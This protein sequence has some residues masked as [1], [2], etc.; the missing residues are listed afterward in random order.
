MS[1][2]QTHSQSM[3]V[4]VPV[5]IY[6]VLNKTFFSH[7]QNHNMGIRHTYSQPV[8]TNTTKRHTTQSL[9][10]FVNFCKTILSSWLRYVDLVLTSVC[11]CFCESFFR[12]EQTTNKVYWLQSRLIFYL[13]VCS[14]LQQRR[15]KTNFGCETIEIVSSYFPKKNGF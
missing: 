6:V 2:S 10:H 12:V 1:R 7:T 3:C 9:A 13:K 14:L 5:N 4:G 11:M 8:S 15:E